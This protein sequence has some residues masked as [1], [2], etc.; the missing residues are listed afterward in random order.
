MIEQVL[1][2]NLNM[3]INVYIKFNE[4][5]SINNNFYNHISNIPNI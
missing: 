4:L 1:L 3:W 5:N 2:L